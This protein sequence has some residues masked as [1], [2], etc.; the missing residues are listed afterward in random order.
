MRGEMK[1]RKKERADKNKWLAVRSF[2]LPAELPEILCLRMSGLERAA[3]E[4]KRFLCLGICPKS[5]YTTRL[6]AFSSGTGVVPKIY[7]FRFS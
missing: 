6:A 4:E 7:S 1:E 3:K 2:V 5:N